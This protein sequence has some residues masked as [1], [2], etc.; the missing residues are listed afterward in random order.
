MR[1]GANQMAGTGT[2]AR[3]RARAGAR[4]RREASARGVTLVE[5]LIVIALMALISSGAALLVFPEYKKARI[6]S[7]HLGASVIKT[8]AETYVELDRESDIQECPTLE[9]LVDERKIDGNK[10]DDPW[11]TP[12]RILCAGK[13]I[14]V[15]SSGNDRTPDTEDD[16]WDDYKPADLTRIFE[17]E[18]APK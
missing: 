10:I 16:I 3:A 17:L 8:A 11:G 15:I 7:A 5:V 6:K 4:R 18:T 14:N 9:E 1:N 2:R 13:E 12:Y